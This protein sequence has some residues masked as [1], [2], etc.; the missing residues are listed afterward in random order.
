MQDKTSRTT[1]YWFS[2][3]VCLVLSH[4]DTTIIMVLILHLN[5][6]FVLGVDATQ[7][8]HLRLMQMTAWLLTQDDASSM[9]HLNWH[10][11][12]GSH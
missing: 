4:C 12:R 7:D 2:L 6:H 3:L 9:V 11:K 1:F 8:Q 10:F 5:M